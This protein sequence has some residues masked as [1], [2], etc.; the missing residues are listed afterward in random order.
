MPAFRLRKIG[1]TLAGAGGTLRDVDVYTRPI[2][3]PHEN[4]LYC[5]VGQDIFQSYR[6]YVINFRDMALVLE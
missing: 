4:Y 2:R 3:P 1:L 5:N 6:A